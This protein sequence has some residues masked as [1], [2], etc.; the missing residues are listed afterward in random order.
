MN[1]TS[2]FEQQL[3]PDKYAYYP[4][5]VFYRYCRC[6]SK[7]GENLVY[8]TSKFKKTRE[9]VAGA[10]LAFAINEA[11]GSDYYIR[12][13]HSLDIPDLYLEIIDDKSREKISVEI[14]QR[15]IFSKETVADLVKRKMKKCYGE[16]SILLIDVDS[17][18]EAKIKNDLDKINEDIHKIGAIFASDLPHNQQKIFRITCLYNRI[19]PN[20][21]GTYIETSFIKMLNLG[22]SH[23]PRLLT[24]NRTGLNTKFNTNL[25]YPEL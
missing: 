9:L 7:Y 5:F 15:K 24:I 14:T 4:P 19:N 22:R 13:E 18:G 8:N 23:Q 25:D 10:F 11:S 3:F 17:S 6:I 21:R 12:P 2:N 1:I 20:L 16:N